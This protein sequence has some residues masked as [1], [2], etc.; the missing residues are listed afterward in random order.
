MDMQES[1]EA[2]GHTKLGH[3]T[4]LIYQHTLSKP[5]KTA[6]NTNSDLG[7]QRDMSTGTSS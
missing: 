7:H 3:T 6:P 4:A 1:T 5:V 2:T